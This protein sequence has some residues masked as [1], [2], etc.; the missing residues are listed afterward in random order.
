MIYTMCK[1]DDKMK[2]AIWEKASAIKGYDSNLYRQ[3]AC[4]A[5]MIFDEYQNRDSIYGWEVDHIYPMSKLKTAG[6]PQNEIDD[7]RNL[8]PL[9]WKNNLSKDAD[10][11]SYRAVCVADNNI[12]IDT[13]KELIVNQ[14]TREIIKHLYKDYNI[15]W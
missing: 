11:P 5:W 15:R 14:D 13:E 4:G 10:Y 12:N 3:D 2:L 6:V 9:N 8:R 7:I 1:Y